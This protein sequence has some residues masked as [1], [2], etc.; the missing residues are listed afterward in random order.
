M[1]IP[2]S[3]FSFE[4]KAKAVGD[5]LPPKSGQIELLN[6]RTA[7][8]KTFLKS[9]GSKKTDLYQSPINY[10]DSSGQWQEI[11]SNLV[12]TDKVLGFIGSGNSLKNNKNSFD[13][14]IAKDLSTR[15][16][17]V[18]KDDSQISLAI[19]GVSNPK[20]QQLLN[21]AD[22]TSIKPQVSN[23]KVLF[24]NIIAGTDLAY[25][26]MA[27]G[28]KEDIIINKYSGQNVYTFNL[29]LKN[30][31]YSKESDGS[32]KFYNNGNQLIFTMP[33]FYMWDSNG[34]KDSAENQT[35]YDVTSEI[36]PTESGYK[37][38][39]EAND[40]WLA[41]PARVFPIIIDPSVTAISDTD[42]TYV[43]SGY[44][45]TLAWD[46][47]ALYV[48][49]GA[50]KGV[51]RTL[52]PIG[53]PD[54]T[55]ARIN[56][57]TFSAW[58][59]GNCSGNSLNNGVSAYMTRDYDP[60][61]VVW[62]NQP[63]LIDI[64]RSGQNTSLESWLNIDITNAAQSW[65]NGN[66]TGSK[67]GS[68][69]LVQI[70]EGNWGFRT[71][72]A[73]NNP[74]YGYNQ[75]RI[76]IDY[77]D[78]GATYYPNDMPST[79]SAGTTVN[80]PV[81]VYNTG[82]NTWVAGATNLSYHLYD[83][84]GA[85]LFYDGQRFSLPR[86]IGPGSDHFTTTAT[87]KI[88]PVSGQ[89]KISWDM[90]QEGVTWFSSQ[91]I[92]TANQTLNVVPPSASS[93]V[94]LGTEEYTATAGP[95]DLASGALSYSV[96]DFT[97]PTVSGGVAM[98][99][100]YYSNN[101]YT[102]YSG[103]PSGYIKNWIYNG[104]YFNGSDST[105]LSNSYINDEANLRP[106]QGTSSSNNVWYTADGGGNSYIDLKQVLNNIGEGQA[107][108]MNNMATYAFVYVLSSSDQNVLMKTGSDD[109]IKVWLN[110]AL[111][112]NQDVYRGYT[113]DSDVTNVTLKKGVN[114][115]LV[116]ISQGVGSYSF[117]LHFTSLDGSLL[118]NL[119]YTTKDPAIYNNSG[120]LGK[121]WTAG[122][123]EFLI[124]TDP[125]NIYYH[126]GNGVVN[127]FMKKP[128]GTYQKPAGTTTNL[129]NNGDG[130]FKFVDKF[131]N[132]AG[133]NTAG[134][135]SYKKD[136]SGNLLNYTYDASNHLILLGSS[137]NRKI[138]FTYN[139]NGTLATASFQGQITSYGY[140]GVLL[141]RV[142]DPMGFII[143][144]SYDLDGKLIA[145]R[146][147]NGY[148]SNITYANGQ[149]TQ[150][151]DSTGSIT[152]LS[153]A[154]KTTTLTDALGRKSVMTF[155]DLN[156]LISSTN[157]KNYTQAYQYDGNY[158]VVTMMPVV[159]END[160]LYFKW[161]YAYDAN[162]NLITETD[163]LGHSAKYTYSSTNNLLE[164]TDKDNNKT[165]YTYSTDGRQKLL[166]VIDP[167]GNINRYS[168]GNFYDTVSGNGVKGLKISETD[169]KGNITKYSYSYDGDLLTVTSPKNEVSTYIYDSSG[170]KI[171]E[172]TA[173]GQK[174]TYAYDPN[175]RSISATTATLTT[176]YAYDKN[177]NKISVTNPKGKAQTFVYN[178]ADQM[179]QS[180]DETGAKIA[181]QYDAVGNKISTIDANSQV[182]T[183]AYDELNQ[184][185]SQTEP[186]GKI[187]KMNYDANGN[188]TSV[189]DPANQT[190]NLATDK[191]GQVTTVSNKDYTANL[192]Y[193]STGNLQTANV[194]TAGQGNS[195]TSLTYDANSNVTAVNSSTLG[196]NTATY[197]SENIQVAGSTNTANINYTYDQNDNLTSV[198]N[199]LTSGQNLGTNSFTLDAD[200]RVN[201]ITKANNDKTFICYDT[202]GRISSVSTKNKAGTLYSSFSYS[203][204]AASNVIR[205]TDNKAGT[206]TNYSYD[207]RNELIG[208][209]GTTYSYDA[210]GNRKTMITGLV[211]VTTYTYD[212]PNKNRLIKISNASQTTNFKYDDN[213]N[214]ISKIDSKNGTTN[215][216]YN[217]DGYF[218]KADLPNGT[219]VQYLYDTLTK[220]RSERI[221]T[222]A[223]GVKTI[224]K[225][226]Y[227]ANRLVSETDE[228]GKTLKTYTWDVNENLISV[229]MPDGKGVQQTYYYLKNAKGDILGM[230]DSVGNQVVSYNYDSWGNIK[231]STTTSTGVTTNLDK[232]NNRLYAGYWYDYTLGLYFMKT[233]MYDSVQGRFMSVDASRSDSSAL[234]L[235][236]YIYCGNNPIDRVDPSGRGWFSKIKN[237]ASAAI[238][239][240]KNQAQQAWAPVANAINKIGQMNIPVVSKIARWTG[241]SF[242]RTALVAT[243]IQAVIALAVVGAVYLAGAAV[244]AYAAVEAAGLTITAMTVGSL[245]SQ[246]AQSNVVYMSKAGDYV[247]RTS[248]IVS[249][250][251]YWASQGRDISPVQGLTNLT[252]G[253]SRGAEQALIEYFGGPNGSQ[254][255]NKINSVSKSSPLY[256]SLKETGTELIT[257]AGF[258]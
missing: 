229:T 254:L 109:G 171:T 219:S 100:S 126:A 213:G 125:N 130:T 188:I 225:F 204:D 96:T 255:V 60:Y 33:R 182:T 231:S 133:F 250:T 235:N 246:E 103:D 209:N 77:N 108:Y 155:N 134:K 42:D 113:V 82:R 216:Q 193:D 159:A 212:S 88:P 214:I 150:V 11:D 234:T 215:Y 73:Q 17:T 52:V 223:A 65:Y 227:D 136:L 144:Y 67:K 50:T 239:W 140:N 66:P 146:D 27:T 38:T 57:A 187:T 245:A 84:S 122:F 257:R 114:P 58:Q 101:S 230:S 137:A 247:G 68:I 22:L 232:L 2:T 59:Y 198:K 194:A 207:A 81:T 135:I 164:A 197:D 12:D 167:N 78:Y 111:V 244:A 165:T 13:L 46:Q 123:E 148:L 29:S 184:L 28:L 6:K 9:D 242:A 41:D 34:G 74:D 56:S 183:Y 118:N 224:T 4:I 173:T 107:D 10:K 129:I 31:H 45:T 161:L 200:G 177:G 206:A 191:T 226:V 172:T 156:L 119:T 5:P 25:Y 76:S 47:R 87:L 112:L 110:N 240:V 252:Y 15:A 241:G 147:K 178:R 145:C 91:G 142:T 211:N 124:T 251:A 115:L 53:L 141:S 24:P 26:S 175:G 179:I 139:T 61:T 228:T 16:F 102:N 196:T 8:S 48:G 163:P 189:T 154:D 201:A 7:T 185:I 79:V 166:S 236:P 249:R 55:Y 208:E 162:D 138:S 180:I 222:S 35:S 210:M 43:Q 127:T 243:G 218:T 158:N 170:Q 99:R 233:R 168:Y 40:V 238:G 104:P 221:E 83:S 153:Y 190:T 71:F 237:C 89:Y 93:I 21:T 54:L 169:P 20:D 205:I 176:K 258:K 95:I 98:S 72:A 199:T 253:Q 32:Y 256:A 75:P 36:T 151:K 3:F 90:V 94:H 106:S 116:K 80:I 51:M 202:I 85:L 63:G 49:T 157:A 19:Q 152:N 128:D 192:D 64:G 195:L 149:V 39:I 37:V 97:A 121:G 105:R 30:T 217:A 120:V 131:G 18:S 70:G 220:L 117:G 143:A 174:T 92:V 181:Y 69:E 44:P 62:N 86:D 23:N 132:E 160:Q 248:D 186:G 203:F 14:N 1:A